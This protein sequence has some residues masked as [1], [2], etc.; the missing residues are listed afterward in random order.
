[1]EA[2]EQAFSNRYDLEGKLCANK[3][4]LSE[5]GQISRMG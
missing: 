2:H 1:M 4:I 3:K 5:E